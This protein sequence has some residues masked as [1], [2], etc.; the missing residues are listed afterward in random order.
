MIALE[1]EELASSV[2]AV[3]TAAAKERQN[4]R[5]ER[6]GAPPAGGKKK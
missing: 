2:L 1:L 4:L 5:E 3:E 6:T